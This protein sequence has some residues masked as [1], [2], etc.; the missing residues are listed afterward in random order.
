DIQFLLE[1]NGFAGS[2]AVQAS[3]SA[4]ET[5][6]L[7][8]LSKEY[9]FIKGVVGWVD[10]QAQDIDQ[11]L[12]DYRSESII[13]GFRHVVEGESDTDFLIRPAVLNGLK[14]LAEFGYTYD[15]LIRPRHY[16]ATLHCVEQNPRLQFVLDHIAKPPI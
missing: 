6:Y 2:V 12:A 15:L 7:V 10:L 11:Q 13:K 16:A 5:A 3:Q 8:G 14:A 9:A 4:M 1:R